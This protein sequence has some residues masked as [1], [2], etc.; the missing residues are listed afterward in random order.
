MEVETKF[1]R[2]STQSKKEKIEKAKIM[3]KPKRGK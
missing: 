3:L 1:L 2:Q